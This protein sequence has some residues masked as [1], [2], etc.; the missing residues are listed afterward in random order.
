VPYPLPLQARNYVTRKEQER[1]RRE[2]FDDA[3][4]KFKGGDIAVRFRDV[5][6]VPL[7]MWGG[8]R[9]ALL[10]LPLRP[11]PPLPRSLPILPPPKKQPPT[12]THKHQPPPLPH[13]PG[14]ADR[15]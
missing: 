1:K 6:I 10:P 5:F 4:D 2:L 8:R 9:P 11:A 7:G 13:K 15:L 14:R 12:H 3:L